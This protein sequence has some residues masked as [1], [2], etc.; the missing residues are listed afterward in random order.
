MN[1]LS[2]SIQSCAV[3][4]H[5]RRDIKARRIGRKEI[6]EVFMMVMQSAECRDRVGVN[7]VRFVCSV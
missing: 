4:V 2:L 7:V 3:H 1:V 5:V 6:D